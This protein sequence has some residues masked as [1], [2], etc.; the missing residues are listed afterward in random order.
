MSPDT[1]KHPFLYQPSPCRAS[2]PPRDHTMNECLPTTSYQLPSTGKVVKLRMDDKTR[3][4]S[5]H[6]YNSY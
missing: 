1:R 2:P 6:S 3:L 4:V 5:T